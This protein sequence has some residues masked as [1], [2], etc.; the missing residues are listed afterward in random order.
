MSADD[1]ILIIPVLKRGRLQYH[2]ARVQGAENFEDPCWTS[3][4]VRGARGLTGDIERA[5]RRAH[6][7]DQ[8]SPSEYGVRQLNYAVFTV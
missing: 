3:N 4:Y 1:T 5:T 2:V 7:M 8:Q 6:G